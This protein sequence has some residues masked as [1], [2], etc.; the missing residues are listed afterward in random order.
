MEEIRTAGLPDQGL[1]AETWTPMF[2]GDV[3]LRLLQHPLP[4]E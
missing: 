2:R 1:G 4:H 3:Y